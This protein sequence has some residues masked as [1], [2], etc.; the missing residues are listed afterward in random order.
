MRSLGEELK[1][2]QPVTATGVFWAVLGA[3][4]AFGVSGGIVCALLYSLLKATG[5]AR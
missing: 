4:W 1:V 5:D 2:S 3:L